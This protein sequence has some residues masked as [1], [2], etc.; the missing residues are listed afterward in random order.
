MHCA[1]V[2]IA[3][4]GAG[5]NWYKFLPPNARMLE[6]TWPHWRSR[7]RIRA[8]ETRPDVTPIVLQCQMH[9]P[10]HIFLKYAR[11]WLKFNGTADDVTKQMKADLIRRSFK[12]DSTH[13]VN[14][15]KDSDCVCSSKSIYKRIADVHV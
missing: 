6:I 5:M 15:Q 14:I 11:L 10:S 4:Q 7:Y 1:N 2:F 12:L 3:V 9:T 13:T 8:I